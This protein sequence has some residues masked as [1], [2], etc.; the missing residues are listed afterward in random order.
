VGALSARGAGGSFSR[1][2]ERLLW[3]RPR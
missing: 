1:L 3:I 2:R